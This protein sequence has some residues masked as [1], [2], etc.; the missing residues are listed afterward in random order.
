MTKQNVKE[1]LKS[2]KDENICG[3]C[4]KYFNNIYLIEDSRFG[5][6]THICIQCNEKCRKW[7]IENNLL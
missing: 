4:A 1:N 5:T 2:K 3:M 7:K 6:K